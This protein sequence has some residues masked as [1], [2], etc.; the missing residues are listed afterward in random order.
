MKIAHTALRLLVLWSL[1]GGC[2]HSSNADFARLDSLWRGGDHEAAWA[3]AEAVVQRTVGANGVSLAEV[4]ARARAIRERLS[5]DPIPPSD[6]HGFDERHRF[7]M[8]SDHLDSEIQSALLHPDALVTIRAAI[9]VGE[10]KLIRHAKGLLNL[11]ARPG[12][13]QL[14][15]TYPSLENPLVAWLTAKQVALESL[16]QLVSD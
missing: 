14:K 13:V 8:R 11:I 4:Q 7:A 9:T 6:A 2:G 12:S 1:L 16:R 5:T 10:L 3:E 15:R